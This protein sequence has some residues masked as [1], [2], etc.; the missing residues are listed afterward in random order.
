MNS[1]TAYK[2]RKIFAA[3]AY[4]GKEIRLTPAEAQELIDDIEQQVSPSVALEEGSKDG[5]CFNCNGWGYTLCPDG[6]RKEHCTVC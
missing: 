1:N 2:W 4:G 5:A 6:K 3:K